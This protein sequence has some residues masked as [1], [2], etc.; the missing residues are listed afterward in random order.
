[1][2]EK[3]EKAV[4]TAMEDGASLFICG[5]DLTTPFLPPRRCFEARVGL[6]KCQGRSRKQ[7]SPLWK[8]CE[9][10]VSLFMCGKDMITP[11]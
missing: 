6:F 2:A 7:F 8:S 4:F 3:I 5:K 11:F 10:H 1:M 9:A